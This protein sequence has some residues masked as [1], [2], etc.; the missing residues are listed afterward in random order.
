MI[1][2]EENKIKVVIASKQVLYRLG[3]KT[4]INVIGVE[5]ELF[6]TNSF[7]DTKTR[8]KEVTD[9]DYLILNEDVFSNSKENQLRELESV[10]SKCKF[11]LMGDDAVKYASCVNCAFCPV[12]VNTPKE[13][14]ETFQYFFFE[15]N[16]NRSDKKATLLSER[17]CEILKAI[18]RG[19]SNKEIANKLFISI[20]TVMTHRK[21]I[22]DKLNI[23][24]I[25]GLTVYAIMN[26]MISPDEVKSS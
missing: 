6:E 19:F 4:I 1:I 17:E 5:P 14:I 12:N 22:T 8:L 15:W 2:N 11:M 26:N 16:V 18:A 20:N 9:L 13:M 3:V 7:E 24:T 21:N 23:K 25:S 10:C